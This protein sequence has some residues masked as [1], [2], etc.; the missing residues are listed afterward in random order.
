MLK[1]FSPALSSPSSASRSSAMQPTSS[2]SFSF[3]FLSRG[4]ARPPSEQ[5][6]PDHQLGQWAP[7]GARHTRPPAGH[8]RP[9]GPRVPSPPHAC[10]GGG[11][12]PSLRTGCLPDPGGPRHH[13]CSPLALRSSSSPDSPWAPHDGPSAWTPMNSPQLLPPTPTLHQTPS[14]SGLRPGSHEHSKFPGGSRNTNS[15]Q[16]LRV[17]PA[18]S[19]HWEHGAGS[20]LLTGLSLTQRCW[21]HSRGPIGTRAAM[22]LG[23][24]QY[25]PSS[26]PSLGSHGDSYLPPALL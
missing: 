2:S 22:V 13:S 12:A 17:P 18:F 8:C 15:G 16:H 24:G 6:L 20:V 25:F 26:P 19:L 3:F 4:Q 21:L 7:L 9:P 14:S 23:T 5:C 1:S 11:L 10:M